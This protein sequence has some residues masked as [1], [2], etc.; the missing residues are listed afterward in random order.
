VSFL[1]QC[2][3]PCTNPVITSSPVNS[4][5]CAGAATGFSVTATG[6]SLTYQWQVSTNG[7]GSWTNVTGGGYSG[8]TT[9]TLGITGATGAMNGYKYQVIVSSGSCNIISSAATLTVNTVPAQ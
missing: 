1:T 9:S 5:I 4:A 2:S 8:T 3:P 6:S 7:G